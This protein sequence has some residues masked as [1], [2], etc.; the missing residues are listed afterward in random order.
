M[1][2]EVVA[3]DPAASLW[4]LTFRVASACRQGPVESLRLRARLAG[5]T[6]PQS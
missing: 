6:E 3:V 2:W 1:A 4:R 5:P